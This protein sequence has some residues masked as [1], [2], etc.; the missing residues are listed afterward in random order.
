MC[1]SS[2]N[3]SWRIWNRWRS[4]VTSFQAVERWTPSSE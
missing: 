3:R 1:T 4:E 2:G